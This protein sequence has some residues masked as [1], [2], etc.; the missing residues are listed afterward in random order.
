MSRFQVNQQQAPPIQQEVGAPN[1]NQA[2]NDV[3]TETDVEQARDFVNAL[4]GDDGQMIT[5]MRLSDGYVSATKMCQS[6]G[7]F[8]AD[9]KDATSHRSLMNVMASSMGMPI[10]TLVQSAFRSISLLLLPPRK[11]MSNRPGIL[12]MLC[13]ATTGR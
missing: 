3:P 1:L 10:D 8:W 9:Y 7:K 12:W 5:D 6:A 2:T 13:G 4:R 11:L